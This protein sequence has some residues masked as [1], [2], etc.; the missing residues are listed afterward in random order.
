MS[1]KKVP[2]NQKS[3]SHTRFRTSWIPRTFATSFCCKQWS[4]TNKDDNKLKQIRMCLVWAVCIFRCRSSGV[5]QRR[6]IRMRLVWSFYIFY[7]F[8]HHSMHF[9][10]Y[11]F[12][13]FCTLAHHDTMSVPKCFYSQF[14]W[15]LKSLRYVQKC[16]HEQKYCQVA[17]KENTFKDSN[18]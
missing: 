14:L 3:I 13:A 1:P 5:I 2:T 18:L 7:C 10:F 16:S 15:K 6:Q 9:L 8:H 17:C 12:F 4:E 11:S